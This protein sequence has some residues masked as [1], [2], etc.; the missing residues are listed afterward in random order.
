MKR[1]VLSSREQRANPYLVSHQLR[2]VVGT[3][4]PKASSTF[5]TRASRQPIVSSGCVV[6]GSAN[7]TRTSASTE[8]TS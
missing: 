3:F 2:S 6:F 7:E 8:S 1:D 4:P 5:E